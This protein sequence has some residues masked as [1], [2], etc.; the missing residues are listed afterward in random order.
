MSRVWF[1]A[2][3]IDGW[4]YPSVHSIKDMNIALKPETARNKLKIEAVRITK[5]VDKKSVSESGR[6]TEAAHPLFNLMKMVI[7]SD[8]KG[9]IKE[10]GIHW[11][12]C[13]ELGGDF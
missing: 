1:D 12:P 11:C 9:T 4:L 5:M 3:D 2:D 8:Y 13:N 6:V 10:D 7:R